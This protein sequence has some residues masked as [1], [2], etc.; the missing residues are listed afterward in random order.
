M[1]TIF[2]S[3]LQA[4]KIL[5]CR[6]SNSLQHVSPSAATDGGATFGLEEFSSETCHFKV[7]KKIM[8]FDSI[9]YE[10]EPTEND[11]PTLPFPSAL[12]LN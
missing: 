2:Q 4:E 12:Q 10:V 7:S 3:Y 1:D 11:H 5:I 8:P 6:V 9:K